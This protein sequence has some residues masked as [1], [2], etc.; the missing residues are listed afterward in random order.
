MVLILVAVLDCPWLLLY[1]EKKKKQL[2]LIYKKYH[3][4]HFL[5]FFITKLYE[6]VT[7]R[8]E[9]GT[10][11]IYT[12]EEILLLL[13]SAF[14]RLVQ[15][16]PKSSPVICSLFFFRDAGTGQLEICYHLS[17]YMF[18][19]YKT[20]AR[21]PFFLLLGSYS[22]STFLHTSLHYLEA[23]NII[24]FYMLFNYWTF[25][26]LP[27]SYPLSTFASLIHFRPFNTPQ[28]WTV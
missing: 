21:F 26:F 23:F 9:P 6:I 12:Q 16:Q 7:W 17:S 5:F 11:K 18:F 8:K 3:L 27:R 14:I 19:K 2:L 10:A 20:F 28:P 24:S 25:C 15:G 4:L 22:F 13:C 1:P